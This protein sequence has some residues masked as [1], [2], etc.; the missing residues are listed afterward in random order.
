MEQKPSLLLAACGEEEEPDMSFAGEGDQ[1]EA[2]L[3]MT[4]FVSDDDQ[5]M[6]EHDFAITYQGEEADLLGEDDIG[7]VVAGYR[8]VD[9]ETK[10][11]YEFNNESLTDL[12]FEVSSNLG[13]FIFDVTADDTIEVYVEWGDRQEET[14]DI[15]TE[16]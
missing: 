5:E 13:A 15:T 8:N 1:W 4:E 3:E 10:S 14:F 6:V 12:T 2:T 9:Q 7:Q 11:T 16:E